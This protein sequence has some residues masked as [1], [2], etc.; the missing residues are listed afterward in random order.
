MKPSTTVEVDGDRIHLAKDSLGWRVVHPIKN[1]DGTVN[2]VNLLVGGKQNLVS[3]IIIVCVFSM[4]L[5]GVSTMFDSCRHLAENPCDYCET[6]PRESAIAIQIN[7]LIRK[8]ISLPYAPDS[9]IP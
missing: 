3:L 9:I 1:E 8:N 6:A 5:F 2:I 7:E 4:I